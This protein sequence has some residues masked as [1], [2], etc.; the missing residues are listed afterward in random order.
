MVFGDMKCGVVLR[1][2]NPGVGALTK[3]TK[4]GAKTNDVKGPESTGDPSTA[5]CDSRF[6]ASQLAWL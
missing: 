5:Y 3:A 6:G 2:K 4:S 1:T